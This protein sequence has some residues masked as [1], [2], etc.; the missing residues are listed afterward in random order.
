MTDGDGW[1]N[2]EI[3]K[4]IMGLGC[5]STKRLRG[6]TLAW[7]KCRP[8]L[9]GD[10]V[11]WDSHK[12]VPTKSGLV[13]P[14]TLEV[15]PM[16]PEHH[17][18]WRIECEYDPAATC[19]WWLQMLEDVFE[20]RQPE[21]RAATIR[22]IQELLGAGLI[23][24]KP[25]GLSRALIFQGGSN[26]GK[27]GL[28]EVLGG[29]FGSDVNSTSLEALEGTHG[30]MQFMRRRP[31]IL[32]EAFDQKKWHLSSSV[33]AIVTGEPI[34]V[35]VK[36]GPM[37]SL[38]INAPIFWGTNHPPQFKESTKAIVTRLV[39]IEC[40]R[41]FIEGEPVGAAVEAF[42]RGMDKP[43]SLV[44]A[45]E[46]AGLLKWA[47]EGLQRALQRGFIEQTKDMREAGE[48]IRIESNLVAGFLE[49]CVVYD[50]DRRVS[51]PDFCLA[52]AAWWLEN[53]GENRSVPSNDVIGKA[54]IAMS[55]SKIA[56]DRVEL[57]DMKRRYYAG[58]ALNEVGLGFHQAGFIN[59]ALEGKTS[60]ASVP[61]AHVNTLIPDS[62]RERPSIQTMRR[63]QGVKESPEE[64]AEMVATGEIRF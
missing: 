46:M 45:E 8:H 12:M 39:V 17:A 34:D 21:D 3:E 56:T 44:L 18:T 38:R 9:W 58:I 52:F 51:S 2:V 35:N 5:T 16:R 14:R 54:L 63:A 23:D 25:R 28:L 27:S 10:K 49:E 32:H 30:T 20:D 60:S 61:G 24:E 22:V 42:K 36:N 1:L 59:N 41:E 55:D 6:E 26:F 4:A 7:I 29:L 48:Q 47:L 13:D 62:W 53:K 31:W 33:K 40:R 15:I 11:K 50:P 19:P 57:R 64:I 37:L 43:S